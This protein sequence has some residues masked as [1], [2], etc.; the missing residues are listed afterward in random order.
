[1]K[2]KFAVAAATA[3]LIT[4]S[5]TMSVFAADKTGDNPITV[6]NGDN[7]D[8]VVVN[9]TPEGKFL[10][11]SG[12]F[13]STDAG[14]IKFD[15]KLYYVDDDLKLTEITSK[16]TAVIGGYYFKD[17]KVV[18]S[19]RDAV[20]T[21]DGKKYLYDGSLKTVKTD[22]APAYVENFA[23]GDYIITKDGE[24]I[25]GWKKI[26]DE[27]YYG[28]AKLGDAKENVW[29]MTT[30]GRWFF[31]GAD[32]QM[33]RY[34]GT[35]DGASGDYTVDK[36]AG[37]NYATITKGTKTYCVDKNGLWLNG[38]AYDNDKWYFFTDNG[39]EQW[40]KYGTK[41]VYV[42]ADYEAACN[43]KVGNYAIGADCYLINGFGKIKD[44]G[45]VKAVYT[46]ADGIVQTGVKEIDGV[47]YAFDNNGYA[48]AGVTNTGYAS[49]AQGFLTDENGKIAIN[50]WVKVTGNWMLGDKDGKPVSDGPVTINGSTYLFESKAMKGA[51]VYTATYNGTWSIAQLASQLAVT[52][53]QLKAVTLANSYVIDETG[54]KINNGWAYLGD[55]KWAYAKD[56]KAYDGWLLDNG[57]WY[58][59]DGGKMLTDAF[60]GQYYVNAN[61]VWVSTGR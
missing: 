12:D 23:G 14:F 54:R 58:Y 60:V 52:D 17:G 53:S 26:G 5:M 31:V 18:E 7:T 61:G 51:G 41:W 34:N 47:K 45:V 2:R 25:E 10:D 42:D 13:S 59:I 19:T 15:D 50:S 44:T 38:W 36:D 27:W 3:A 1:M 33:A 30:P 28:G 56:G 55:G 24:V 43:K 46:N 35:L 4:A 6:K 37:A 48:V 9:S 20:I 49:E 32:G 57:S 40:V 22:S 16:T 21:V 39:D 29:V 11:D 8:G